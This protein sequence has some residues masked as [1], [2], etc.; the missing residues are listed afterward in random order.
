MKYDD[1][2]THLLNFEP[3]LPDADQACG[4]HIGFY[5]AWIGNNA[6]GSDELN[7]HAGPV[8]QRT[9]SGRE[10][11]FDRCDGKLLSSDLN[12]RGNAFTQ[13]YYESRYFSDYQQVFAIDAD[14]PDAFFQV[15]SSWP[16]YEKLSQ[17]LDA[18]F[19]EWQTLEALP[20]KA[21]LLRIMELGF[22][23]LLE[24]MGFVRDPNAFCGNAYERSVFKKAG[25]WREWEHSIMLAAIDERPQ[26]YGMVVE[27]GSTLTELAQAVYDD[28]VI[29]NPYQSRVLRSTFNDSKFKW[30]G[31]WPVPLHAF[32]GGPM[33]A[34]PVTDKR[35]IQPAIAMLCKR[36]ASKLPSMLQ[37]LE[38]LEGYVRHYCATPLSAS[39]AFMEYWHYISPVPVLCAE[40]A[41]NPR[42][43]A[44]C[45]EIEQALDTL[46]E[47]KQVRHALEV[48]EMRDR[49]QRLRERSTSK[50]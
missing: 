13:S 39:P 14:D 38:T 26:F 34:I 22:V 36:A 10:L 8:R 21:E 18:R 6:L 7:L 15:E 47:F 42:L 5:L 4:T 9:A 48:K 12:E 27:V 32:H 44:I 23:P 49:L 43:L 35:Q 24:Q 16:N 3:E 46:P 28:A 45:D 37:S 31:D 19:Q 50:P 1:A 41:G 40:L 30:L 17:R 25:P 20:N 2:E 29:D 11:L 33:L